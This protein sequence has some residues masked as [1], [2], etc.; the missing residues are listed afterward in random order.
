M[1]SFYFAFYV[2]T[3]LSGKVDIEFLKENI[4]KFLNSCIFQKKKQKKT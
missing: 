4:F 2:F 3:I 1:D